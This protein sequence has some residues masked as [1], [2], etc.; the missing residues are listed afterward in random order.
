MTLFF[1]DGDPGYYLQSICGV[2]R[3]ANI[4]WDLETWANMRYV[5]L[6]AGGL[7]V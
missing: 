1:D 6:F 4:F 2:D 5:R 3:D 7:N